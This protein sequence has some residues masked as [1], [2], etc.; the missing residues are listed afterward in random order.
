MSVSYNGGLTGL[1]ALVRNNLVHY[2]QWSDVEV[3]PLRDREALRGRPAQKLSNDDEEIGVEYVLP[4]EL[5]QYRSSGVT[6]EALDKVF[7]Q[8]PAS[9]KRVVLAI[10]S[11]DGTV[12]YY[13]VYQGLQRPRKN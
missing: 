10:S 5:S 3:V 9:C 11:D 13:T 12:V 1:T 6:L 4:V 7:S 8:L 2:Q